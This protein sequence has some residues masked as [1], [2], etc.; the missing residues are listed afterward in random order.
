MLRQRDLD[1]VAAL[2]PLRQRR[3]NVCQAAR[4]Q[5]PDLSREWSGLL[6]D[7][8]HPQ[9]ALPLWLPRKSIAEPP[10]DGFEA[11]HRVACGGIPAVEP[12]EYKKFVG[13]PPGFG[14]DVDG[15]HA[16]SRMSREDQAVHRERPSADRPG[17]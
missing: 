10:I 17:K 2:Q 9:R 15:R 7:I 16:A 5:L 1:P 8:N 12:V 13:W 4:D 14:D 3:L 11:S 6:L